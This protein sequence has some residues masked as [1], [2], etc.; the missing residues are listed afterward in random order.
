MKHRGEAAEIWYSQ[1]PHP[2]VGDTEMGRYS[3]LQK[4]SSRSK[5]ANPHFRLP[6]PRVMDQEDAPL[7]NLALEVTC[8][9][10]REN[11]RAVGNGA[12][13]FKDTCKF[14]HI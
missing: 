2:Q 7:E 4:F 5:G 8:G 10:V 9:H 14:S 11:W 12:Q 6:S 13:L 1:D 3:Q